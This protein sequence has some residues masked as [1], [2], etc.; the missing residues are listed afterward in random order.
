MRLFIFSLLVAAGLGIGVHARAQNVP[1]PNYFPQPGLPSFT[2]PVTPDDYFVVQRF[3]PT[4]NECCFLLN[5]QGYANAIAAAS[6]MGAQLSG[7]QQQLI[8]VGSQV[9]ALQRGYRNL[10]QGIAMAGAFNIV[11]PNPGD[12]F[13]VSIGGAGFD[14][15]GAGSLSFAARVDERT[16][17][18]LGYAR[19]Q[20]QNLVKGG[21]SFSIH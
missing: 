5:V 13:S 2:G 20:T 9:T 21:A 7:L 18:Y 8:A 6:A 19:S 16:I 15:Y 11:P 1:L 3:S 10:A 17:L 4:A 12:R 14:G